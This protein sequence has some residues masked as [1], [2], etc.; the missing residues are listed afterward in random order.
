MKLT[1]GMDRAQFY[2]KAWALWHEKALEDAKL[3]KL[4]IHAI[5]T[6]WNVLYDA[7]PT[8]QVSDADVLA[9][10]PCT[11]Y[12]DLPDGGDV[13]LVEQLRRM[14]ADAQRWRDSQRSSATGAEGADALAH[15]V[16]SAAQRAPGEGIEDAV[17]RVAAILS[18]SSA[19]A[20]EAVAW[21]SWKDGDGYGFWDTKDEA[22]LASAHDF[23]PEPLYA[24]P[25]PAQADARDHVADARNLVSDRNEAPLIGR[26]HH[27][28]GV[29]VCGTIRV[30]VESFDTQP[31]QEFMDQMFDWICET[32]NTATSAAQADAR[33]GLTDEQ[34]T[35]VWN[36]MPGGYDGFLKSWGYIQFARRIEDLLQGASS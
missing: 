15:E 35:E 18:R 29:L 5:R 28:N 10:L 11:H 22:E 1:N 27:G 6:L 30:A 31:S 4:S 21:R 32:L 8:A 34:I 16:W 26:W 2:D 19:M 24:A 36:S 20:A 7:M 33:V 23:E 9:L 17:Q 25:Q 14:A 3:P 12:M 13:S